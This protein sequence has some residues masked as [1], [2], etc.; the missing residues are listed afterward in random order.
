[1]DLLKR[2]LFDIY[3]Y[4]TAQ[5]HFDGRCAGT[6]KYFSKNE[7]A[8]ADKELRTFAQQIIEMCDSLTLDSRNFSEREIVKER[9]RQMLQIVCDELGEESQLAMDIKGELTNQEQNAG[10]LPEDSFLDSMLRI[11]GVFASD[12]EHDYAL[13]YDS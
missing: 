12:I 3:V 8:V 5:P 2:E 11:K 7:E 10:P 13:D 9:L 4:G 1:M 6:N